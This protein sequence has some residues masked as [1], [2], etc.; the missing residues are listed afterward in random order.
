[1][2]LRIV[3]CS[4]AYRRSLPVFDGYT[5]SFAPGRTVLLGP[6]G[7]GKSTLLALLA[8]SLQ[9]QKGYV[10]TGT[11][12]SPRTWRGRREF[13][14]RVAWLPQQVA[15]FPGLT[16]REHVAYAG[17]LKGLSRRDAWRRSTAALEDVDLAS[18]AGRR[19]TQLSGGQ[20]R[21]MGI[22]GALVHEAEAILL[23]EPT[24]GLDPVADLR[25]R[26]TA[27]YQ[28]YVSAEE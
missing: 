9:P 11:G 24:A 16:V 7:A 5:A 2:E 25:D 1:M 15:P 13:R 26:V 4:F 3:G 19:A 12:L 28:R 17:W 8:D 27:A 10:E 20:T 14:R 23:D 18:L 22:A 6:N 21:R